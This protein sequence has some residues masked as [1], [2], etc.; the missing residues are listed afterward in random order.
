MNFQYGQAVHPTEGHLTAAME[1]LARGSRMGKGLAPNQVIP[2]LGRYGTAPP[3][4]LGGAYGTNTPAGNIPLGVNPEAFQLF[5]TVDTDHSGSISVSELSRALA[6]ADW[7]TFSEETCRMMINMFDRTGTGCLDVFGFT[8][9][10]NFILQWRAVFQQFDQDRS[11][12]I[13]GNELHQAL[14]QMGYNVSP[15]FTQTVAGQYTVQGGRP[16][17]QLDRFIQLC[18]RMQIMTQAFKER[19][20]AMTGIVRLGYEDFLWGTITRIM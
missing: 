10:W 18:T 6:N 19:D 13:D 3:P 11:G 7:T 8:A 20:Q 12:T 9:L 16:G 14:V 2:P 4:T 5:Q 1:S 15:Q 17:I